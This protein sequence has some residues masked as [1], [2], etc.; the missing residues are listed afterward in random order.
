MCIHIIHLHLSQSILD[1]INQYFVLSPSPSDWQCPLVTRLISNIFINILINFLGSSA[2]T[3]SFGYWWTSG[4]GASN[5]V[6]FRISCWSPP[7]GRL[8]YESHSAV[9]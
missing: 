3:K 6:V 9:V 8:E 4:G 7:A 5:H 2:R 1:W